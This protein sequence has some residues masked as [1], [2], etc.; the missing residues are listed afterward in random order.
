MLGSFICTEAFADHVPN[1]AG[2]APSLLGFPTRNPGWGC[3]RSYCVLPSQWSAGIP[4]IY[5]IVTLE[6][7]ESA[8]SDQLD[9]VQVLHVIG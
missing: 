1:T 5:R 7:M 4:W 3:R 2:L 8:I 6:A 9:R